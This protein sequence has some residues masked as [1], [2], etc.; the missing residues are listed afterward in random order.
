M[1]SSPSLWA[2]STPFGFLFSILLLLVVLTSNPILAQ[3]PTTTIRANTTTAAPPAGNGTATNTTVTPSRNGTATTSP[4]PLP[5]CGPNPG[6]FV[7]ESPRSSAV[8]S[9]GAPINITWSY[10][11]LTNLDIFPREKI[12]VFWQNADGDNPRMDGWKL[13]GETNNTATRWFIWTVPQAVDGNYQVRLVADGLDLQQA[14]GQGQ[15]TPDGFPIASSSGKFRINN[16]LPLPTF[17]DTLGPSSG[18]FGRWEMSG[19]RVLAVGLAV[20]AGLL[21]TVMTLFL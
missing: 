11:K 9:V 14:S 20:G 13:A 8:V 18:V 7:V 10:S 1:R 6:Q 4:R 21:G 3:T 16:N 5:T 2:S 15:C 17:A 12:S 19:E